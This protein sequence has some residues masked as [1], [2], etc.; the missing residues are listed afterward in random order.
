MP[1]FTAEDPDEFCFNPLSNTA[2]KL[3][4]WDKEAY[5]SQL[6]V[7]SGSPK[8]SKGAAESQAKS[9]ADLAAVAAEREGLV[10]PG[11]ENEVKA[12]KRKAEAASSAAAKPKKVWVGLSLKFSVF[13][14]GRL[15][16][17]IFSSG[18]IATRSYT[19]SGP[20]HLKTK[21]QKTRD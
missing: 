12:K 15:P 8:L 14:I 21:S 11:K 4:Y 7:S 6:A 13:D 10:Q 16:P 2:T 9:A 1:V 17:L 18:A 3:A 5:V 20:N 19:A